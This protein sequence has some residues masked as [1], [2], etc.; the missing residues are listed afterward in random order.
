YLHKFHC[1]KM[2]GCDL[3]LEKT[4]TKIAVKNCTQIMS[5]VWSHRYCFLSK[6]QILQFMLELLPQIS[7]RTDKLCHLGQM[8]FL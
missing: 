5:T 2:T 7:S 6:Y 1:T 3:R 4:T 8:Q